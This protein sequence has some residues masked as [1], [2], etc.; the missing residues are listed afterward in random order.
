MSDETDGLIERAA[1]LLRQPDSVRSGDRLRDEPLQPHKQG[2]RAERRQSQTGLG[3]PPTPA[4]FEAGTQPIPAPIVEYEE[5]SLPH[6]LRAMSLHKFALTA[7]TLLVFAAS[8]VVIF[9]LTP[10]YAAVAVVA[11]GNRAS[12]VATRIEADVDGNMVQLPPDLAAIQTQVDYLRSGPVAERA[13]DSLHLWDR[14]EFN[15]SARPRGVLLGAIATWVRPASALVHR[16]RDWL[17]GGKAK[18]D[19]ALGKAAERTEA[20]EIFLSNLTV[21]AAQNSHIIYV[22]F[23]ATDPQLAAAAANA[24]ADQYIA[25]QIAMASGAAQRATAGLEQAVVALRQRVAQSDQAYERYRGTF[26]AHSGRELLGKQTEEATKELTAAEVA[27]Q[28]IEA[29]LAALRGVTGKNPTTDATSEVTQSRVMQTLQE[30]AAGLQGRLAE[31]SATLGDANP[32]IQQVRAAISRVHGEMH[33]EVSRQLA[34]L[35]AE[36]KVAIAREASLRQSL[37]ASATQSAQASP[38]QAKLDA[39]KVEAE[40]NRAVLN[41]FLT[42]LHEAKTS[43]NLLQRANAEIVAHAGVPRS[44]ASPKIKLL[45]VLAA[46]GST[47]AGLGVAIG[48][49]RVGPTFRSGEEIENETG[50]RT[51]A[52]L[53]LIDNPE[54]PPEQALASPA[55]FYGEAIRTLYTTLLLQRR[56]RMFVVTSARPGDGKTT[57]AASL[58]LVAAKAGR[59]V[60]LIDADLCTAGASRI[61]RLKGNDGLAE[62]IAGTRQ[63]SDVVATAGATPTFHFLAAGG[64]GNALAAR[65]G[66]EGAFG[67][68][69]RLRE[70]YDLIFIDSPPVLAVADAMHL[71]A[72]ADAALFAVRWGLTPRAAVKLGLRRLHA[73]AHGAAVGAVLTMVDAREHSRFGYADSPFY[74]KDLVGYYG[75][76]ARRA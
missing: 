71:A 29:R 2:D 9:S 49:E 54:A 57:L 43:A 75:S 30:Q 47:L 28:V 52:L 45:L 39:L 33:S 17:S 7:T 34:A 63:F 19:A 67:L 38:G 55:S 13:M 68:F 16:W 32:Q 69:R 25:R 46:F 62:L 10:R 31:L 64:A 73:S 3:H 5:W 56:L 44:P 20:L 27:R 42:R 12:T 72:Q 36:L 14:P 23:E 18:G 21:D 70:E 35:Q 1:A 15:P 24:V 6:L 53:P 65:S 74:A 61:F 50:V 51:L 8:A 48:L 66:L 11:V 37:A 58:A 4:L 26:E 40:A 22:R 60:L 41:S 76:G 59:R